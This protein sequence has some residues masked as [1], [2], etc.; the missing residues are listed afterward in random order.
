MRKAP[1]LLILLAA[2]ILAAC[3]SR[4]PAPKMDIPTAERR[5]YTLKH[6]LNLT[7]VQTQAVK[8]IIE[9]EYEQKKNFLP[10]SSRATARP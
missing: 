8:P 10:P 5:L 1:I 7:D 6:R 2:A 3:S 4:Q 9:K